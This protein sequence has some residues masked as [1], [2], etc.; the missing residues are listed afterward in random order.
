MSSQDAQIDE[1]YEDQGS[2]ATVVLGIVT[3]LLVALL[4]RTVTGILPQRW[5]VLPLPYTAVLLLAGGVVGAVAANAP[6][7]AFITEGLKQFESI[8]PSV[9]L[10][11]FLPALITPS[12]IDLKWHV[13]RLTLD[14]AILL[15]VL[16]T[17]FNAS[18]IAVLAKFMFPYDWSWA[19]CWLFAAVLAAIDPVAVVAI[20]H[21]TAASVKLATMIEGESLLND[22]VAYVLFQIFIGWAAGGK[23]TAGN[24]VSF[25]IKSCLGSPSLGLA[26]AIGLTIWFLVLFSDPI[27]EIIASITASY[28]LWLLSDEILDI[29]GIL[30]LVTFGIGVS[31]FGIFRVS[32]DIDQPSVLLLMI[33]GTKYIALNVVRV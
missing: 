30:A 1:N 16:G 22:G 11:V 3:A 14:K 6:P 27:A 17:L 24:V 2:G 19:G 31:A 9:L 12:A 21:S 33:H 5:H 10:S 32:K 4:V 15:A 8:A 29:S 25:V 18:I 26:W 20:M 7:V 28:A 23:V 13:V